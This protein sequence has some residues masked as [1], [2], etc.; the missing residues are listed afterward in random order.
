MVSLT[1]HAAP[2]IQEPVKKLAVC[3]EVMVMKQSVLIMKSITVF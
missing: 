1:N 2:L 3:V